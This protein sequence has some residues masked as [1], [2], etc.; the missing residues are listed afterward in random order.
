MIIINKQ[1]GV[2]YFDGE[3]FKDTD[4]SITLS[5]NMLDEL[6]RSIN[7]NYMVLPQTYTNG[8]YLIKGKINNYYYSGN[9]IK[10]YLHTLIL[11]TL[12][13]YSSLIDVNDK[14]YFDDDVVTLDNY[15][16]NFEIRLMPKIINNNIIDNLNK[17]KNG[18]KNTQ[19]ERDIEYLYDKLMKGAE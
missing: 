19:F 9:N 7:S 15:I 18:L 3:E 12:K 10:E 11:N 13:E 6:E 17:L 8:S 16:I 2:L 5:Y 1:D 4:N 14:Y